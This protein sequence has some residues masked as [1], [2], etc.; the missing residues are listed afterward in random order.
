MPIAACTLDPLGHAER[1]AAW[2]ALVGDALV[3]SSG[4]GDR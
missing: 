2:R 3:D 4:A 1:L